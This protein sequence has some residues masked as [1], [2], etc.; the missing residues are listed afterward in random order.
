M[1]NLDR[2]Y[3]S[4]NV[5][6]DISDHFSQFCILNSAAERPKVRIGKVSNFSKFL[7]DSFFSDLSQ[8]D[9]YEIFTT[10]GEDIID[11]NRVFS[12]FYAKFNNF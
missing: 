10:G 3:A 9:W 7:R 6:L 8:L 1:N 11:I 5:V 4:G 12:S 2:V